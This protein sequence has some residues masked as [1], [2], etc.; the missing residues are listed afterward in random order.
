MHIFKLQT[1][2]GIDNV[3]NLGVNNTV[4]ATKFTE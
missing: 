2:R 1:I 3:T 4:P